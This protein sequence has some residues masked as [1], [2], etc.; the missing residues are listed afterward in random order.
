[1]KLTLES[2]IES[3]SFL[4][5]F[6]R[7]INFVEYLYFMQSKNMSSHLEKSPVEEGF[8]ATSLSNH[9]GDASENDFST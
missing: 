8:L 5:F 2:I 3:E 6:H 9:S 1:M 4:I 7:F